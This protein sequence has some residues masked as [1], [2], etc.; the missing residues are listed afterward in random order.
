MTMRKIKVKFVDFWASFNPENNYFTKALKGKM[1]VEISDEPDILFFSYFG[2]SHLQY[3]C[4]KIQFLG[5]NVAPDFRI[6]DYA[7]SFDY[8]QQPNHLRLPLYVLLFDENNNLSNFLLPK[9]ATTI[10]ELLKE[11]TGFCS[12]VVSSKDTKSRIDFFHHLSAYKKVDSG[13]SVLNNVGGRVPDKLAFIRK[14]KFNIAFENA[15]YPGYVTEKLVEAKDANTVPVYWGNPRIAE[16]MNPKSF[17]NYHDYNSTKA[18]LNR[19][20]E[21]DNDEALYKEYLREPL[22][23]NNQPNEYFDDGRFVDFFKKIVAE[24]KNTIPVSKTGSFKILRLPLYYDR[25]RHRSRKTIYP[26]SPDW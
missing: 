3:R 23:Y 2:T 22:F 4:H 11:K 7:I 5:E 20:I 19:V 9:T 25:T 15:T 14:Y 6:A 18:L 8:L 13:G 17:I 16:E 24:I 1:E 10:D 12:F 21:V 26:Y